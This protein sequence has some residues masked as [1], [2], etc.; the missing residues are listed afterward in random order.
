VTSSS[1]ADGLLASGG[2]EL[3]SDGDH[4]TWVHFFGNG[5]R[6]LFGAL[7]LPRG[8]LIGAVLVCSPTFAEMTRNYR[9]EVLLGRALADRGVATLRFHYWAT[10]HSGGESVELGFDT[11]REDARLAVEV[12]RDLVGSS[13]LA[14]VGTRVGAVIAAATAADV[15]GAPMALW[16]P[17]VE[18]DRYFREVFRARLMMEL[19]QGIAKG[20]GTQELVTQLRREGTVEVAGYP[21]TRA[22]YEGVVALPLQSILPTNPNPTLIIEMNSRQR[23]SRGAEELVSVWTEFGIPVETELIAHSEAW[24]FGANARD[25]AADVGV[26]GE[27]VVPVTADFL[28]HNLMIP[29]AGS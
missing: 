10:G 5:R 28:T 11:M 21:I 16:D 19:K 15:G 1:L 24:W 7:H 2:G 22:L 4:K 6:R 12:V 18:P 23:L 9:R 8:A 13:P 17:V 29:A 20:S 3:V 25:G 26:A 27:A 14:F